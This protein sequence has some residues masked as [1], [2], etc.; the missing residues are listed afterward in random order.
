M[1]W[2][3]SYDASNHINLS[4]NGVDELFLRHGFFVHLQS[5]AID[6]QGNPFLINGPNLNSSIVMEFLYQVWA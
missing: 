3:G 4:A 5:I 2:I 6:K 1:L